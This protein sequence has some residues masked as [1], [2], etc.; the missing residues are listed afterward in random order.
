ME[1]RKSKAFRLFKKEIGQANHFL[2][3]ILIGLDAVEDGAKKKDSFKTSWNPYNL[4]ATVDRSRM[5]AIK[6]SLAWVVDCVDMYL[7][8]CNQKPKLLDE[9]KA[10][11]FDGTGHSVYKKY[12]L[13]IEW[14]PDIDKNKKAFVDLLICWRNRLVHYDAD[15]KLLE[16]TVE[17]FR[18][19]ASKDKDLEKFNFD[20]NEMMVSFE[21]NKYPTFKE[22][23]TMISMTISFIEQLDGY[24]LKN[25]DTQKYMDYILCEY[26][27]SDKKINKF[28]GNNNVKD[29]K[30]VKDAKNSI[31]IKKI[32]YNNTIQAKIKY[33][34]QFFK[35]NGFVENSKGESDPLEEYIQLISL[36]S[37]EEVK[38]RLKN[39]SLIKNNEAS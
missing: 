38:D 31:E 23:A 5:F 36:L 1:I 6:S 24:L 37:V 29:T 9:E 20:V 11:K 39:H 7:R 34:K 27:D 8:V 14:Y 19:E 32:R 21:Q 26:L 3:T 13:M 10:R 17:Y 28:F 15:N 12:R 35:T 18:N 25:L 22:T 2:I 16:S 4:K 30:E 33:L